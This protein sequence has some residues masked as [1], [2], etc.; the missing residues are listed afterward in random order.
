MWERERERE[1]LSC[2]SVC[3]DF[4][5]QK[6]AI[7]GTGHHTQTLLSGSP[8]KERGQ[9]PGLQKLNLGLS[10]TRTSQGSGS[11]HLLPGLNM[12]GP[13]DLQIP[14]HRHTLHHQ[15]AALHRLYQDNEECVQVLDGRHPPQG[16]CIHLVDHQIVAQ[17]HRT[18][19][20]TCLI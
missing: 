9:T 1:R 7:H 11:C 6:S 16:S 5:P 17:T 10:L 20:R 18:S 12:L 3:I 2:T 13:G 15:S 8:L 19:D 4:C 14:W